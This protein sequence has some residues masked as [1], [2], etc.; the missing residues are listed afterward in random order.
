M[1]REKESS[2]NR[3]DREQ[4]VELASPPETCLGCGLPNAIDSDHPARH[5]IVFEVTA[6]NDDAIT[7]QCSGCETRTRI[8][9][10]ANDQRN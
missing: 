6:V 5:E 10:D 9:T 8:Q 1:T 4:T 7:Y 3:I 2:A